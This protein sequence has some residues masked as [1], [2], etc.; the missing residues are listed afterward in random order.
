MVSKGSRNVAWDM[1]LVLGLLMVVVTVILAITAIWSS[2][3]TQSHLG[4]TAGVLGATGMIILICVGF[5][6]M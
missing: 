5:R 6:N 3:L 1:L 2:G 4:G